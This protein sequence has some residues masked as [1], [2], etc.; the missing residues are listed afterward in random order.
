MIL[1]DI[2]PFFFI[3]DEI[4]RAELSRVLGELMFSIE[5]RGVGGAIS[6]QYALLNTGETAMITTG[7]GHKFFIPHNIYVIGT[8]N[9]IDRS[10]ESFDL[11]LRRRF[12]W[13]RVD[14]DLS[15]LKYHLQQRDAKVPDKS[16]HWARLGEDLGRLNDRIRQEDILGA[17]YEVGHAYCMDLRYS[18]TLNH[19]EVRAHIW[20]DSI[21]PLLEE[22]LR[23]S[24]RSETLLP[25]FRKEFGVQ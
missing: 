9:M 14:P 4:N 20:E 22:Y 7:G 6:T 21:R 10:V 15:L 24:G 3:I 25:E 11:A 13:E 16:L 5:Y 18:P 1:S 2:F 8:M 23:G 17:D 19:S 12:R